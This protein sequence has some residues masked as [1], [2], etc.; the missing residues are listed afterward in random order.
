MSF[1][2]RVVTGHDASGRAVFLS[3]GAPP[4][5]IE[6]AGGFGVSEVLV[7]NS[8][9]RDARSGGDSTASDFP[10]HPAP[11]GATLRV[12]RL[13]APPAGASG[14]ERWL[15]V[16]G[17][18][19]ARR[20]WHTTDTLDFEVVL[21]GEIALGLDD[22]D[23]VLRRGDVVVQRATGHRWRVVGDRPCT[24][25]AAML[26]PDPKAPAPREAFAPRTG[27]SEGPGPRR[28]VTD[29]G[30]D[31]RSRALGFGPPPSVFRPA[32]SGGVTLSELWQTGGPLLRA[33]QG[34]D[35]PG[36]WS[37]EPRGGGIAFRMVELPAG[38]DPGE[39]GWH[40]TATIDLDLIVSGQVELSLPELP[41]VVLGPGDVVVQRATHHRWR[42]LGPEP[43][44][45]AA[46]MFALPR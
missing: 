23:H 6:A 19:P 37:L 46:L 40:T 28:L 33:E 4:K 21:D 31:G 32:G 16:Q 17:E 5:T 18:D 30:P 14:E 39:A 1:V 43:L 36:A 20:G 41:P 34:G 29:T 2:R 10:L 35:P 44:R 45:M 26:R 12:I 22:G 25:L 24:Y 27:A 15:S 42:P 11:G 3:D 8:A 38:D 7:F 13:P 9:P